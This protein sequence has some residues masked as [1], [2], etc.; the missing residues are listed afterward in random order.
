MAAWIIRERITSVD[1]L[2]EWDGAGYTYDPAAST[3]S[4]PVFIR[5]AS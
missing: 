5:T 4:V 1:R 2:I 3:D